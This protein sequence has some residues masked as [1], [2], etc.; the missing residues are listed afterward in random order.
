[1]QLTAT[2]TIRQRRTLKPALMDADRAVPAE[3]L[4]Q[5][6][7]AA[8]W[9]PTHGKTQPWRFYIFEGDAR[10]ALAAR[11]QE[12]YKEEVSAENFREDKFAKLATNPLL[13]PCLIAVGVEPVTCGK[14]PL[15]E[16]IEAVACAVQNLMLAATEAGLGSFWSSPPI[17]YGPG[18]K[19][20]LGLQSEEAQGLGMIYLGYLRDGEVAP[21]SSREPI[22]ER[23]FRMNSDLTPLPYHNGGTP[24]A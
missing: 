2:Q 6:L 15:V 21:E 20:I 22:T 9:A 24:D 11:L 3:L 16:E 10:P 5:I 14:I 17:S 19:A 1:M 13:A 4:D 8:N 7:D 18:M 23:T 12:I